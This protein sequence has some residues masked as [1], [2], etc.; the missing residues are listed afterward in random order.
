MM[1]KQIN[2]AN[3]SILT[4][5]EQP[6]VRYGVYSRVSHFLPWISE[7]IS[8]PCRPELWCNF[9]TGKDPTIIIIICLLLSL[10]ILV[11]TYFCRRNSGSRTKSY[12]VTEEEEDERCTV[13][14]VEL[15][16]R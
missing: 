12:Q 13:T 9:I 7:Q 16:T 3:L 1:G 11:L 4:R 5:V 8:Q 6:G 10:L 2:T 14:L 15:D